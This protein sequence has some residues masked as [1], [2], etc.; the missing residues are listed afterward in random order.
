MHSIIILDIVKIIDKTLTHMLAYIKS[1][2]HWVMS[3]CLGIVFN[4][5]RCGYVSATL[6]AIKVSF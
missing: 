2:G 6:V 3:I 5:S 1:R 4:E